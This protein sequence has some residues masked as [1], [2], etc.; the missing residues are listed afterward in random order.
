M[1]GEIALSFSLNCFILGR[2]AL[3]RRHCVAFIDATWYNLAMSDIK[4]VLFDMDGT[5]CNTLLDL[6]RA[7]QAAMANFGCPQP[8]D[9]DVRHFVGNGSFKLIELALPAGRE[10][11]LKDAEQYFQQY[12]RSHLTVHTRPYDGIPEL[13]Q[14]L[15]AAGISLGVVSN[16]AQIPLETIV[17]TFFPE[18][19]GVVVGG[20]PDYPL[21]PAPDMLLKAMAELGVSEN[22]TLYIGDSDVDVRAAKNA[23][24]RGVF[25]DW[26]FQG[27]EVLSEAGAENIAFHPSDILKYI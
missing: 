3:K 12:Y 17:S 20:S 16:K 8:T 2:S 11:L 21:K 9:D 14:R 22:E 1:F 19:F 18:T 10:A 4:C 26:G 23:E 25:C 24:V 27:A 6:A 15:S 13:L 5:L 7:V